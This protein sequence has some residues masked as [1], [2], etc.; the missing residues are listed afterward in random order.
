MPYEMLALLILVVAIGLWLDAMRQHDHA[1]HEARRVCADHDVQ[2]LDHSVGLSALKLRRH[3]G[4]L[5]WE[6][7]YSFEVSSDGSNRLDGSLWLRHGH[8]AGVSAAWLKPAT[9]AH[10]V[11]VGA[12]VT[13]LLDRISRD[14][15][16]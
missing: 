15:P 2:L 16:L 6:R 14:R 11:H 13:R 4:R 9:D 8:L 7:R 12:K 10:T 3:E 5:A 1:L